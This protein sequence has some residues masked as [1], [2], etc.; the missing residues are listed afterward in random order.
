MPERLFIPISIC[1]GLSSPSPMRTSSIAAAEHV[2]RD[3]TA[4]ER[5]PRALAFAMSSASATRRM[6]AS[7]ASVAV[8][9]VADDRLEHLDDHG[10]LRLAVDLVEQ[11]AQLR[12][13]EEEAEVLVP[14]AV[15]GHADTV[16]ER[17]EHHRDL[18]VVL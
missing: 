16:E 5:D 8:G 12:L 11:L 18:R 7:S 14:S 3:L 1:T 6:P 9:A 17:R 2:H 4:L 13:G 10:R 15:D